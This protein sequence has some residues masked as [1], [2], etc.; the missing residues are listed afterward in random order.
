MDYYKQCKLKQGSTIYV[1][2]IPSFLARI[3]KLVAI[4]GKE[5]L[6]QVVETYG[7]QKREV[8]DEQRKAHKRWEDVI[9]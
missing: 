4:D 5:G 2:W 6:W 1:A 3:G 9:K 7:I 8:L